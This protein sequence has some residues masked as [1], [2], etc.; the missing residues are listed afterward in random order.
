MATQYLIDEIRAFFKQACTQLFLQTGCQ[1]QPAE[2]HQV[3]AFKTDDLPCVSI[4]GGNHDLELQL[5]LRLPYS[6][7][8]YTYPMQDS[9][10][11]T[12]DKELEDW[13]CE[14][15]NRLLGLIKRQLSNHQCTIQSGLPEY[16]H[17]R[18]ANNFLG[19]R[20]YHIF[21]YEI[22][23]EVFEARIAIDIVNPELSLIPI[24]A[25]QTI[26]SGVID[27]F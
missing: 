12:D 14:L 7:L 3:R 22:E 8:T 11:R 10:F 13:L 5:V 1:I 20:E 6:V 2:G 19:A 27:F 18:E 25:S 17:G 21:Y 4:D 15:G 24:A 9:L 26:E 16:Y 23:K